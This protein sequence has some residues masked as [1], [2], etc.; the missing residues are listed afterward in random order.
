MPSALPIFLTLVAMSQTPDSAP[1]EPPPPS[2]EAET[3]STTLPELEE[4]APTL[5]V[6]QPVEDTPAHP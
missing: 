4:V 5:E 3:E 2:E 6:A 1:S